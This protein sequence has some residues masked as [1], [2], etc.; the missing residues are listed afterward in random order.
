MKFKSFRWTLVYAAAL[1]LLAAPLQAVAAASVAMI[2][3][4]AGKAS[5][6]EGTRTS[7]AAILAYLPGGADL[8]VEPG[9]RVTVTFFAKPVALTLNG[10]A[11]GTLMADGFRMVSGRPAQARALVTAAVSGGQRFEAAARERVAIAAVEMRAS[12][13][14]LKI[15][16]PHSPRVL[17]ATPELRWSALAGSEYQYVLSDERGNAVVERTVR[18]AA[19]TLEQ[20]LQRGAT[21]TLRVTAKPATGDAQTASITF[22]VADANAAHALEQAQPKTGADFTER[23]LYAARL[24]AEG[25]AT[26]AARLWQA[27][28]AERPDD[29][30]LQTLAKPAR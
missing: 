28:A 13:P 29:D 27:L 26:D 1:A 7:A 15:L 5:V 3:D 11:R 16:A 17:A 9:A 23:V 10:P 22:T 19:A 14:T 30:T 25:Y 6:H 8:V 21:Y 24:D 20:P 18:T 12:R 4:L 2:T